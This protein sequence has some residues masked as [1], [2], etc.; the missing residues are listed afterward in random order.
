MTNIL[1]LQ[2]ISPGM[3]RT[4][5]LGRLRKMEDIEE[6]KKQYGDNVR[7][8]FFFVAYCNVLRVV[9]Y[10]I[11]LLVK[12]LEAEDITSSIIYALSTPPRMQVIFLYLYDFIH[13][14]VSFPQ[15]IHDILIR[16]TQQVH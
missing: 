16:P 5:F 10:H 11:F 14:V 15:Q 7:L 8:M 13:V 6:S 4:E 3:V 9:K 12:V 1:F 2:S